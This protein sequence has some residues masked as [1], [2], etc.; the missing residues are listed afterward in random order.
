MRQIIR[1]AFLFYI[2]F[3]SAYAGAEGEVKALKDFQYWESGAKKQCAIYDARTGRLRGKVF[4]SHEGAIQKVEKFDELGNKIEAA[5]YD[6]GGMP[7]AGMDGWAA[8]RWRYDGTHLVWQVSYDE[9][10]KPIERKFYSES[11]KLVMRL[12][13]D[14]DSVNPYVNAAMFTMLGGQ[15]IGYYDSRGTLE[16]VTRIIKE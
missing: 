8:M 11:G 16:E 12:Y 7:K 13:R 14:D 4:Y 5:L 9:Y 2:S 6:G 15:N 1:A 10:G 3:A